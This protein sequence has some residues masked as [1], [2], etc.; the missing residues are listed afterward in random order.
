MDDWEAM[1]DQDIDEI[2][3]KKV[4][5]FGDEIVEK[6]KKVDVKE[7]LEEVNYQ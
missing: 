4:D 6:E 3:I 5:E 7:E 2:E 1:L